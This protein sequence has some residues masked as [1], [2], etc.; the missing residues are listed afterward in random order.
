MLRRFFTKLRG[1]D[2]DLPA[3][4]SSKL[5]LRAFGEGMVRLARRL[6]YNQT[7]SRGEEVTL[8]QA[9]K[10]THAKRA[11]VS[12]TRDTG[13]RPRAMPAAELEKTTARLYRVQSG[14]TLDSIARRFYGS[15]SVSHELQE[16]NRE[17][18]GGSKHVSPGQIL[19]LPEL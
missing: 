1:G 2:A 4:S 3:V 8:M 16:M 17:L 6:L 12:A 15:E 10:D 14:D 9:T 5:P 7:M 13:F 19:F 11:S 18:L